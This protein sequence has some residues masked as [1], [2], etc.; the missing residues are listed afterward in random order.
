MANIDRVNGFK[1]VQHLSGSPYTGKGM[2]CYKAAGTTVT[3]DLFV[4]DMV[5]TSGSGDTAGV[6]GVL[7][8]TAGTGNVSCGVIQAIEFNADHL[9]RANWID[10]ADAGYVFVC[11]DPTVVYEAQANASLT[12][13][14]I[15]KNA[16]M[17]Q[18]AAGS[19]TAGTSGQEVNATVSDTATDQLKIIGFVQRPDNEIAAADTKVLV[20]IN[21]HEFGGGTGNAGH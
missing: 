18:T 4:G 7:I 17:V 11:V 12:Y 13:T 5:V 1:P 21:N 10:G 19:R 8:A 3:H 16:P 9:D 20:I 2:K 6:M 15:G 14:D